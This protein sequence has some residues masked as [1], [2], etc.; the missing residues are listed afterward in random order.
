MQ[1][2]I[3]ISAVNCLRGVSDYA[4]DLERLFPLSFCVSIL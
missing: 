2:D 1:F 4:R 3:E